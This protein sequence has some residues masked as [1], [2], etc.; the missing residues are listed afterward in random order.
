MF[1]GGIE[2]QHP[3]VMGKI[4][5]GMEKKCWSGMGS[6]ETLCAVWFHLYNLENVKNTHRGVLN[7]KPA[8]LLKV[9]LHHVRFSRFLNRANHI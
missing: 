1:S 4:S 9:T 2:K 5:E 8:A 7:L 6:Y 3:A